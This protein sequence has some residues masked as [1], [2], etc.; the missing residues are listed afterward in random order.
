LKVEGCKD[1]VPPLPS[2]YIGS[3]RVPGFAMQA[4]TL[5]PPGQAR[6]GA[7]ADRARF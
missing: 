3:A 5:L 4:A 1:L 6:R 7:L 2:F